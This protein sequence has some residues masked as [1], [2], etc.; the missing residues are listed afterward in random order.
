MAE[1]KTAGVIGYGSAGKKH[2]DAY[3]A[4]GLK[5]AVYDPGDAHWAGNLAAVLACDVVSIC[6]PDDT[7]VDYL[8][9]ALYQVSSGQ[10]PMPHV[11]CEKPLTHNAA[12]FDEV[13]KLAQYA[14]RHNRV[15]EC[16]LPLR[17]HPPFV[18]AL[19]EVRAGC[20]GKIISI[21]MAYH[22][23]R[24]EKLKG[25][26]GQIPNYS[27]IVGGGIHLVD[28][29]LQMLSKAD[30]YIVRGP[31]RPHAGL[32]NGQDYRTAFLLDKT[33]CTLATTCHEHVPHLHEMR[34]IGTA[35]VR[36][37]RNVAEVDHSIGVRLFLDKVRNGQR[38]NIAEA[39]AANRICID[40]AE[41]LR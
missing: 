16:H 34:I 7:H 28:L 17:Y 15:F 27:L 1:I 18:K 40:I 8:A 4:A 24:P 35:G 37:I 13:E 19:G 41:A 20:L 2:A 38:G 11:L 33:M 36:E 39:I 12:D 26:R 10:A 30:T 31:D 21:D 29:A 9:R 22:Y 5:V 25:W 3:D 14:A 23:G 32:A 6:S